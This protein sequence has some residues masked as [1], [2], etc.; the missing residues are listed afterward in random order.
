M[1]FKDIKIKAINLAMILVPALIFNLSGC[2]SITKTSFLVD[3]SDS[4]KIGYTQ[5][6]VILLDFYDTFSSTTEQSANLI[7]QN[8]D[9]KEVRKMALRWKINGISEARRSLSLPD[10]FAALIDSRAYCYQLN[11]FFV[12]G[13][14]KNYFGEYQNI[15]IETT[16]SLIEG[17]DNIA[18]QAVSQAKFNNN[19]TEFLEWVSQNPILGPVFSRKSTI[20]LFV[21]YI[22]DDTKDLT[23][24]LGSI[25][26]ALTDMRGGL[27][28]FTQSLLKQAQWQAELMIE[29]NLEREEFDR[30]LKDIDTIAS[31]L[32]EMNQF[33]R[34]LDLLLGTIVNDSFRE[35]NRQRLA[36]MDELKSERELLVNLLQSER[37][38]IIDA[39][40]IERDKTI[41]DAE[42]IT[43]EIMA[44]SSVLMYDLVDHIFYRVIQLSAILAVLAFIT[45]L[46][47]RRMKKT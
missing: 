12:S 44:N 46:I 47:M 19:Q 14:G 36:T 31:S 40:S 35:V 25:E 2:A 23:S 3:D 22:G 37:Q 11:Q 13:T 34:E 28:I 27:S 5:L 38:I 9:D 24:S 42:Q 20:S 7:I 8:T 41:D 6:K 4:I 15:A 16:E 26:E 30:A 18:L 43:K 17:I 21:E 32:N 33:I 45:I 1:I 10:P 39:V 29:E